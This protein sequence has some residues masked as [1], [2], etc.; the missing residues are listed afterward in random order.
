MSIAFC[1][2]DWMVVDS[3]DI[4]LQ[5]TVLAVSAGESNLT[6]AMLSRRGGFAFSAATA[7]GGHLTAIRPRWSASIW[8]EHER[9]KERGELLQLHMRVY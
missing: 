6:S 1:A 8:N 5:L 4:P 3:L 7:W 9:E 2:V